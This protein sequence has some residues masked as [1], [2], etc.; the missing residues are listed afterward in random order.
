[1][2]RL[3]IDCKLILYRVDFAIQEGTFAI[4]LETKGMVSEIGWPVLIGTRRIYRK[5]LK[6]PAAIML[7]LVASLV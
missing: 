2:D 3:R 6:F 7:R 4:R 5:S 1:M